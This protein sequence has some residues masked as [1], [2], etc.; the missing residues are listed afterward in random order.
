LPPLRQSRRQP[1]PRDPGPPRIVPAIDPPRLAMYALSYELSG[2]PRPP[3]R[4]GAA[5]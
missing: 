2:W 5:T 4:N 3:V 1:H